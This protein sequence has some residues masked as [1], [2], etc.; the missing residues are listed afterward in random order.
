MF[1]QVLRQT[2]DPDLEV[3]LRETRP[4]FLF[5]I[6]VLLFLY[7]IS[8]YS[9]PVLRQPLRLLPYTLLFFIHV[10]LHWMMPRFVVQTSRTVPYLIGQIFLIILL[11]ILSRQPG[12]VI[13][14]FMALAGETVG[15]LDDLP[16]AVAALAGYVLLMGLAYGLIWG[17]ADV[18]SWLGGAV[19]VLLFVLLYVSLFLRQLNAREESQK[20]LT[21]LQEAHGQLA[22]YAQQVETLTLEGER[23]R[24]ARELHDTLAQGLAGIVLQLEALEVSLERAQTD[25]AAAIAAQ[26]KGRARATLA[27]ARRAIDDL[28]ANDLT[29]VDAIRREVERF[30]KATGISC[31]LILPPQLPLTEENGVHLRRAV[32]EGLANVAQHAQATAARLHIT[33]SEANVEMAIHDNGIGFTADGRVA[34]GHYGLIGLRERARLAGGSLRITSAPDAGTTLTF[35]LPRTGVP[36][37]SAA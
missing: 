33:M 14:L 29:V 2:D 15:I 5:L 13:G 8:V 28:R 24:M 9:D 26:A 21:E 22:T 20:L 30:N 34:D 12:I 4:F 18:P 17:W 1:K 36:P 11:I 35:Q 10:T 32:A 25:R 3:G 37:E 31:D 16:R 6:A 19:F 23:Q 7:G 27:D